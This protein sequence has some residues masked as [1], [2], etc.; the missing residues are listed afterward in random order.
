MTNQ[1]EKHL[2]DVTFLIQQ[3]Q[4]LEQRIATLEQDA[5]MMKE[6]LNKLL[7]QLKV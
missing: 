5:L 7:E 6:L 3:N 1:P 4:V 2:D